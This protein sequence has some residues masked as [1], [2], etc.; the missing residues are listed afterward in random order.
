MVAMSSITAG[1]DTVTS[2]AW[3]IFFMA[4]PMAAED[5]DQEASFLSRYKKNPFVLAYFYAATIEYLR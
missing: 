5:E 1:R 3:F 4:H 2:A